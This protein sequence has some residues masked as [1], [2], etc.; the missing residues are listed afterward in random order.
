[1][2]PEQTT[3]LD[4][5]RL[6]LKRYYSTV[7]ATRAVPERE[8]CYL[9]GFIDAAMQLRVFTG[10]ELQDLIEDVNYELFGMSVQE[11]MKRYPHI[12]FSREE[13]RQIPT[14]IRQG[15]DLGI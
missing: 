7:Q 9:E 3:Y 1:M 13:S 2:D 8:K 12:S 14:F 6:A 4:T 15:K 5:F 11:R 10:G